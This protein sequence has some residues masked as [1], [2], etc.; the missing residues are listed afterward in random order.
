VPEKAGLKRSNANAAPTLL[1]TPG[2]ER[3]TAGRRG[4]GP[5]WPAK[6]GSP[7]RNRNIRAKVRCAELQGGEAGSM[8]ERRHVF[9][10][11][12]HA[13]RKRRPLGDEE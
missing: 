2:L 5:R 11:N 7:V 1:T 9:S 6:S 10:L 8:S 4:S 12:M 13:F 3:H